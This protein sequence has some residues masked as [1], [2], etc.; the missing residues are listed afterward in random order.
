MFKQICLLPLSLASFA[1]AFATQAYGEDEKPLQTDLEF[2]W[3][4]TSGNTSTSTTKAVANI[5][6]N[7]KNWRHNYVFTAFGN[8]NKVEIEDEVDN[9]VENEDGV[10]NKEKRITTAEKYSF[11]MKNTFKLDSKHTGLFVLS[12]YE[13]DR[14]SGYAYQAS[15]AAGYANR[16]FESK[17][18][19]FDYSVG[20]GY[21]FNKVDTKFADDETNSAFILRLDLNYEY[22]FSEHAKFVQT[23]GSDIAGDSDE[24]TKTKSVSAV[25]AN[26]NN[27]LALKLALTVSHNSQVPEVADGEIEK[28]DTQSSVT[29]VYS[30]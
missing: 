27:A 8:Q 4:T 18:S 24:N 6:Q 26:L 20:P 29:L 14:F 25:T 3:I 17:Q 23:I 19:N 16:L 30:F 11:T 2:S 12:T 5:K 28:R 15:I 22:R 1:F 13:D 7:T 10:E 21:S 9:E